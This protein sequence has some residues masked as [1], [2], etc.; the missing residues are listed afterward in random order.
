MAADDSG[1]KR[2]TTLELFFDLVFVFTI[3]QLTT[4]LY[5]SPTWRGVVQ[6]VLM[7]GV[8]WWMYGG[9]AWMTNA[10]SAH[11]AQRRLLLLGGMVG[12]FVLALSVPHAFSSSG[13]AFGLAYLAIVAVHSTL[14]T[15]ASSQSAARAIL[16][17]APYNLGSALVIVLGGALG[18]K[19]QY[20]L[21]TV[22]FLFEWLTPKIRRSREGGFEIA[23]A[24]FVER[25][26]L[27]VLIAIGESIVAIGIGAS[28]LPV[29]GALVVVAALGLALSA[30]LWWRYFGGGEDERAERSLA[31]M[32]L[33][34]R[35]RAALQGYG[36][37]HL[38][39]LLGIVAIAAAERAAVAHPFDELSWA[40]AGLL[41][42]GAAAFLAGDALFRRELQIGTGIVP[43]AAATVAV[44][45]LPLGTEICA[46]A[47]IGALVALLVA[48]LVGEIDSARHRP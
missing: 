34:R 42:G 25:H 4:V 28:H 11:T 45:T 37:W 43:A 39:L 20:L 6:V 8:I 10:V 26:G 46:A 24:H 31:A 7:L 23:A 17:L 16:S 22:A 13:L 19:A 29:D 12:Y 36:Y 15:R 5:E 40:R 3:T 47:Q 1:A 18:G 33:A 2:V 9:Y 48:V 14:F 38:P 21:W 41:G 30:G 44:A 32:P 35:S 27:V